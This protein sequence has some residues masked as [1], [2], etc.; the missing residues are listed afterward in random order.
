MKNPSVPVALTTS[1]SFFLWG[2]LGVYIGVVL[3]E[4][5][6]AFKLSL[7][8]AGAIFTVWSIGFC[9]GSFCAERLLRIT[10][11]TWIFAIFS[12]AAALLSTTQMSVPTYIWFTGI[13]GLLGLFGGCIFTASHTLFGMLFPKHRSA[14]LSLLDLF[15]S[16]GN[17]AAPLLC[18]ALINNGYSWKLFFLLIG[19]GFFVCAIL[20]AFCR[21]KQYGSSYPLPAANEHKRIAGLNLGPTLLLALGSF[22]LGATEWT[23]NVW[24]VTYAIDRGATP[25]LGRFSLSVFT[26]GMI[27]AR[28]GLIILNRISYRRRIEYGL[29]IV[30]LLG[31]SLIVFCPVQYMIAGNLLIGIGIGA[32][33][34]IFLGRAMDFDPVR[35]AAYSMVMIISLTLGGQIASIIIGLTADHLGVKTAYMVIFGFIVMMMVNFGLMLNLRKHPTDPAQGGFYEPR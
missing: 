16:F 29:F 17:M 33:L 22:G 9:I 30:G 19:V 13:Y 20:F 28:A 25:D 10:A 31:T 2:M 35:S 21:L 6:H 12:A 18:V 15:F 11:S 3:P 26:A 34:P 14:A 24:F 8:D 23:Q 4:V 32:L 27:I 5:T 1:I 7:S